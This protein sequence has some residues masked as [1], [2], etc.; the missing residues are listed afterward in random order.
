MVSCCLVFG[1]DDLRERV[2]ML[3]RLVFGLFPKMYFGV[4]LENCGSLEGGIH[5]PCRLFNLCTGDV[6]CGY[7]IEAPRDTS[8][9]YQNAW[10]CT[11]AKH[12]DICLPRN[13]RH[14]KLLRSAICSKA[15]KIHLRWHHALPIYYTNVVSYK[16]LTGDFCCLVP[17]AHLPT[18]IAGRSNL[19]QMLFVVARPEE[20]HYHPSSCGRV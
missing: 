13:E 19:P 15:S 18:F 9:N 4:M 1:F 17:V 7:C 14:M 8:P 12:E 5:M 3:G 10:S 20:P 6:R 11:R 2:L 16:R